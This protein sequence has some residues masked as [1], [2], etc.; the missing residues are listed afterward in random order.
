M[1]FR[2]LQ[3][4]FCSPY[5]CIILN[6]IGIHYYKDL[7]RLELYPVVKNV[8]AQNN[9]FIYYGSK[10]LMNF[11]YFT[12]SGV[13]LPMTLSSHN[14]NTKTL[15]YLTARS[16]TALISVSALAG[17]SLAFLVESTE[18]VDYGF[19][20][21]SEVENLMTS[22]ERVMTYTKLDAEVGY[23]SEIHPP[24][25]WPKKGTIHIKDLSF[26]YTESWPLVLKDINLFIADKEKVGVVGRTGAGKSS[27][28]A[29]LLRM[30][31]PEGKVTR[32]AYNV[33][34]QSYIQVKIF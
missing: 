31:D 30:P 16:L 25:S 5:F 23:S 8:D 24:D 27:L 3:Q 1:R 11:L 12:L 29:S 17:I 10:K 28:V 26:R 34:G 22:V 6:D 19:R 13:K 9:A 7:Y 15:S 14:Y 33:T 21:A 32:L 20:V 18:N 4:G 2:K